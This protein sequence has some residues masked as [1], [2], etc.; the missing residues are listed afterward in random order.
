MSTDT[1]RTQKAVDFMA[2]Q[3]KDEEIIAAAE[4]SVTPLEMFAIV[5]PGISLA[6]LR[7][8]EILNTN[9][10]WFRNGL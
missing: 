1:P 4:G 3:M 8:L 5:M 6:I 7:E 10:E 9:M 2:D